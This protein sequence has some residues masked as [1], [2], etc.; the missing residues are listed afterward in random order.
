MDDEINFSWGSGSPDPSIRND[1]FAVR[2][3]GYVIPPIA[4]DY[5]FYTYTDDGARL[6]IDGVPVISGAWRDMGPTEYTS[7]TVTFNSCAPKRIEMDY[8]ENGGGAVALSWYSP[9]MPKE[10]I[11][12][13]NLIPD[14]IAEPT[15]T[16]TSMPT[17]VYDGT[18][19]LGAYYEWSGS[20][21]FTNLSVV[22][23]DNNVDFTWGGGGP[24]SGLPDNYFSVRWSGYVIPLYPG[25]YT[26]YTRSDDGARLYVDGNLVINNAWNYQAATE[27][28]STTVTFDSCSAKS[29]VMEYFEASGDAVAQLSWSTDYDAKAIIPRVNLRPETGSVLATST[30]TRTPTITNT[31]TMTNTPTI[32]PTPTITNTPTR[33]Y[34]PSNTPTRTPTRTPTNTPTITNTPTRTNTPTITNTPTRTY[35]PTITLTP[36]RTPTRTPTKTPRPTRTPTNTPIPP[37]ATRTP[38]VTNTPTRTPTRTPTPIVLTNTPT[39]SNTPRPTFTPGSGD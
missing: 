37:T 25:D 22:R 32:T 23:L 3:T 36:S 13:E 14:E 1:D 16:P 17:C 12:R 28:S 31:P 10:V 9:G 18:G 27:Y 35:T 7:T 33:T 8:Y 39:P 38:T 26:F 4:G 21:S 34:T 19:I 5:T 20:P 11:P 15:I 24:G 30:P 29:I 2:W 6:F